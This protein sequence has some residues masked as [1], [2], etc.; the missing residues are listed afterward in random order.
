MLGRAI[1]QST[2]ASYTLTMLN[3]THLLNP[4][5]FRILSYSRPYIYIILIQGVPFKCL[6]LII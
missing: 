4:H 5:G 1:A 2:G 6:T 3:R